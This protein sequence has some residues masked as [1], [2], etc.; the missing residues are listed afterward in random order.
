[1]AR[2]QRLRPRRRANLPD[3]LR[4]PPWRRGDGQHLELPGYHGPRPPGGVGGLAGGLSADPTVRVVELPRR[5]RQDPVIAVRRLL[6]K[7]QVLPELVGIRSAARRSRLPL[8]LAPI[9]AVATGYQQEQNGV[10]CCAPRH[11][12]LAL[13]APGDRDKVRGR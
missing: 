6:G 7:A 13:V 3:L 10:D 2:D 11:E 9:P 5:V 8:T 1:V 12:V 4:R